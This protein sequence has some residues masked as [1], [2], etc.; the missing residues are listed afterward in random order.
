MSSERRGSVEEPSHKQLRRSFP[1][2]SLFLNIDYIKSK[3]VFLG[4]SYWTCEIW[5]QNSFWKNFVN[6]SLEKKKGKKINKINEQQ[7]T[8]W[9][10]T[11]HQ[12]QSQK[13]RTKKPR[14]IMS[15]NLQISLL[16]DNSR[17]ICPVAILQRINDMIKL[18]VKEVWP[19]FPRRAAT[20][21]FSFDGNWSAEYNS[22]RRDK[23]KCSSDWAVHVISRVDS[24]NHRFPCWALSSFLCQCL[25]TGFTM[26]EHVGYSSWRTG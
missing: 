16:S 8:T 17:V 13:K 4:K 2:Y 25:R 21:H 7:Q 3:T 22:V 9:T 5:F 10:K 12:T 18:R 20:A 11:K 19:G 15:R 14:Q 24:S 23:V 26:R 6:W 1:Q